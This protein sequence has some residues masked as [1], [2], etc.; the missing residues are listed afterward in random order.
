MDIVRVTTDTDID[1]ATV[2]IN[3]A[4]STVARY[5]GFTKET[6]PTFPAFI[7][8]SVIRRQVHNGLHLYACIENRE[9]IGSVGYTQKSEEYYLVERLAVDPARRHEGT[10]TS[11]MNFIS[12]K[13]AE[14]GGRTVEVQIVRENL[15]LRNWY[16][17]LGFSEVRVD[18][19]THLPFTVGV[20][21][22]SLV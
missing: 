7:D 6:V 13:I 18:T 15:P 14:R 21:Q 22:R 2:L 11:L 20:L 19:Y 4:F 1:R 3:E 10:G 9:I 16:L 17:E 8:S 12:D 5:F